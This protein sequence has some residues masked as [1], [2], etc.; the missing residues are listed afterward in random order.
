MALHQTCRMVVHVVT[1]LRAALAAVTLG[2]FNV[3]LPTPH[4]MMDP[5]HDK[6]ECDYQIMNVTT[7]GNGTSNRRC[8]MYMF[9]VRHRQGALCQ[10]FCRLPRTSRPACRTF[11]DRSAV[12]TSGNGTSNRRCYTCTFLVRHGQGAPCQI[13]VD[14]AL[15]LLHGVPNVP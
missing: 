12:T 11:C 2:K 7:S 10:I 1:A 15:R 14:C 4:L 13:F 9:L 5:R 3:S 8:Y 6:A